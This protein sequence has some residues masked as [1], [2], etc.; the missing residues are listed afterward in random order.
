MNKKQILI[1]GSKSYAAQNLPEVLRNSEYEITC[2]NRGTTETKNNF[3]SGSVLELSKN[4]FLEKSYEI[5]I[6][7]ILLKNESIDK[8]LKYIDE[9]LK[10][11]SLKGTKHLIHISS[12][13]V[14]S[15]S[16]KSIS[17]ESPIETYSENKG[18]YASVK[19]EIDK[20]LMSSQNAKLHISYVRPGF[21]VA[22]DTQPSF[23]GILM[24]LAFNIGLLMGN[25]KT[26]LPIIERTILH[27][28][29]LQIINLNIKVSVYLIFSNSENTKFRF[30]KKRSKYKIIPL[31]QK[32]TLLFGKL[33]L[34]LKILSES[35]FKQI[36]G[37]FKTT[38]YDSSDTQHKLNLNFQ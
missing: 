13:S 22:N 18:V 4:K 1:L 24:P 21:I 9:L 34:F 6:N 35:Q 20:R 32:A 17:E 15:N 38:R 37:L 28:A 3:V 31:P 30:V 5:V 26:T 29:I 25:K 2:F 16:A 27:K 14:Y 19:I 10:F 8:N 36:E 33:L 12:M 23:A 11:C 7:F